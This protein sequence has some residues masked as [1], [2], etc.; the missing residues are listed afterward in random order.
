[1]NSYYSIVFLTC[2][3]HYRKTIRLDEGDEMY[4]TDRE[5]LKELFVSC[6]FTIDGL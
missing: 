1:M 2:L 3:C 6:P 5:R 4:Q